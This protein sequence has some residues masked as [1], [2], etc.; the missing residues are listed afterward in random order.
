MKS[1]S[2]YLRGNA[3]ICIASVAES[4]QQK[5]ENYFKVFFDEC[6]P[7]LDE[8]VPEK[9]RKFKGQLIESIT[10]SAV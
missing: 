4:C 6:L 2:S 9:F 3:V 5:F 8:D 7:Y 10:I 1:E